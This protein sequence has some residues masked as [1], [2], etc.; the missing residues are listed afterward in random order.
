[1]VSPQLCQSDMNPDMVT[2][3]LRPQ[4]SP[5]SYWIFYLTLDEPL[6]TLACWSLW[7]VLQ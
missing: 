3:P 2:V 7:V 6:H 1:L 4:G 5:G